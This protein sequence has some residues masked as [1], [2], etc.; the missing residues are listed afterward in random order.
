MPKKVNR[1]PVRTK[2]RQRPRTPPP[3]RATAIR[4]E[5][6]GLNGAT[7]VL[8]SE[9]VPAMTVASSSASVRQRRPAPARRAPPVTVVNY[10]YLRRDLKILV[11]LAVIMVVLLV[12]AYFVFH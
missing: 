7:A 10:G 4:D 8:E 6:D 1:R 12:G 2:A 11:V 5:E 3:P 9:P